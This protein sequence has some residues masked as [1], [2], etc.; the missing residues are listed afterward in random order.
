MRIPTK[1][2][3]ITKKK[4]TVAGKEDLESLAV[5]AQ[6]WRLLQD[7][8]SCYEVAIQLGME[9]HKV[10]K[11][12]EQ[13]MEEFCDDIQSG[14]ATER[15]LDLA[16]LN[17][18][19]KHYSRIAKAVEVPVEKENGKGET[20]TEDEWS[21]SAKAGDLCLRILEAR[22]KIFGYAKPELSSQGVTNNH[23]LVWLKSEIPTIENMVS[24]MPEETPQLRIV[25]TPGEPID[26]SF[27][28]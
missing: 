27:D 21:Y 24:S 9:T 1:A 6:I 16:R 13:C 18:L 11:L 14:V 3:K 8:Y 12:K 23:L 10:K 7:G 25:E 19:W 15:Q 17:D 22:S 5:A 28:P 4:H 2:L 20:Y 26:L